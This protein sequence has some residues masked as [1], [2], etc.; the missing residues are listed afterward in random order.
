MYNYGSKGAEL[1]GFPANPPYYGWCGIYGVRSHLILQPE[2]IC[3]NGNTRQLKQ[4]AAIKDTGGVY[5]WS[6]RDFGVSLYATEGTLWV[7][8][9]SGTKLENIGDKREIRK[10]L[11]AYDI[12]TM[13][14]TLAAD[15]NV[16]FTGKK[17]QATSTS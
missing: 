11:L 1:V 13:E 9:S 10:S 4:F 12:R 2:V 14:R 3:Y 6:Y 5:G 16:T 8:S 7:A 17:E 15:R